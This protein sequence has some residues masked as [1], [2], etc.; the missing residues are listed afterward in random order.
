MR[1]LSCCR[2]ES[3]WRFGVYVCS[4]AQN[5]LQWIWDYE[6][7]VDM[8]DAKGLIK[9]SQNGIMRAKGHYVVTLDDC[10]N[11]QREGIPFIG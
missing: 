5:M 4:I 2:D 1:L 3:I 8:M 10:L 11:L 6:I 7:W 9:W